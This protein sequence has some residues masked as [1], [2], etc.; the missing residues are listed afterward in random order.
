[1]RIRL[2]FSLRCTP[3]LQESAAR[4][5]EIAAETG[6]PQTDNQG[7]QT[8]SQKPQTDNNEALESELGVCTVL[9][10]AVVDTSSMEVVFYSASTADQ[11]PVLSQ[12]VKQ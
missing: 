5:R 9:K 2:G 6:E 12:S 3:N 4:N 11:Q 10:I 7:P 1:V 8:D